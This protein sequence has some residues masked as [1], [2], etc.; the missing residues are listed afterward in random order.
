MRHAQPIRSYEQHWCRYCY[1]CQEDY[2]LYWCV[3]LSARLAV[4]TYQDNWQQDIE[5]LYS[6][7]NM[8]G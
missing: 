8:L 5:Y 4:S 1:L 3:G 2:A 7:N 6:P